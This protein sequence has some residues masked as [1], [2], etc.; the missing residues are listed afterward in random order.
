MRTIS[1]Q[2]FLILQQNRF[3]HPGHTLGDTVFFVVL[4]SLVSPHAE[5]K[6]VTLVGTTDERFA[7]YCSHIDGVHEGYYVPFH[8]G[9]YPWFFVVPIMVAVFMASSAVGSKASFGLHV[10]ACQHADL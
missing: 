3:L 1:F 8:E 10:H 5:R 2:R 7:G 6:S 4:L 9:R